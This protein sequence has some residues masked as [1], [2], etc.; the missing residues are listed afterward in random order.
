MKLWSFG[1]KD[2]FNNRSKKDNN[3]KLSSIVPFPKNA[4]IELSNSCNHT[5]V[6]CN[7]GLMERK[8]GHLKIDTYKKFIKQAT[9]LGLKEIGLYST[10]EPFM[11]K[12]LNEFVSIAKQ[13]N[14]E[15]IYITTNGSL[16]NLDRIIELC[17]NGLSSIKFSI[18]AATKESYKFIHGY[19][20][21]DKVLKNVQEIYFWKNKNKIKLT[22]L[23]SLIYTNLTEN[24]IDLHKKIFSKYFEDI[25]Y[26]PASGQAGKNLDL[27]HEMTQYWN[28][29]QDINPCKMIF[30][31][32]HVTYEGYLTACCV[33]YENDLT[34][35]DINQE[36][37]SLEDEWNN[38]I[39]QN[40]RLKHLDKKLDNTLC[41]GCLT[42]TSKPYEPISKL[43]GEKANKIKK[44]N[45]KERF[46]SFVKN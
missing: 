25:L 11:T 17:G 21:F 33:D 23:G 39:I 12:N 44:N 41:H 34:Y 4:L 28:F 5:C 40:L 46:S 19:D 38:K 27:T 31:R 15:K 18:N 24:E 16:A 36:K 1:L 37:F 8:I 14:I 29:N 9:S 2:Y 10:G 13:N 6:F 45:I 22:L 43:N 32:I 30:N 35:S 26:A 3:T 20:D 7:N 42:G